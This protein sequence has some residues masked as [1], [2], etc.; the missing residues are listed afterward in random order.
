MEC[1]NFGSD[2]FRHDFPRERRLAR[3][4][5][6]QL[7]KKQGETLKGRYMVLGVL[8][9]ETAGWRV[10]LITTRKIGGAVARNR[11]RRRFRELARLDLPR[12]EERGVWLVMVAR[13]SAVEAS[14]E[15]LRR[16]WRKLL[17]RAGIVPPKTVEREEGESEEKGGNR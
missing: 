6:F 11:V 5:E 8:K 16:E 4:H 10:G 17:R 13:R 14:W 1:G 9:Q 15:E 2:I 7:V 3:S 12:E